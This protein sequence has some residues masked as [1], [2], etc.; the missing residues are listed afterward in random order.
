MPNE[1]ANEIIRNAM[2]DPGVYRE[3]AR[4]EADVWSNHFGDPRQEKVRELEVQATRI[5]TQNRHQLRL[6]AILRTHGIVP[7]RGLSLGCGSGRAERHLIQAGVCSS[8]HGIDIA[9]DAI[10]KARGY[11]ADEKVECTYE[12]QDLNTLSLPREEYD[13]VV[14]QTSL[15]H[16]LRLEHVLDAVRSSLKPMG[17]FW[18]HDY[19]GESQFQFSDDRLRIMNDLL[20]L[21]PE[22]L[23]LKS[24][25]GKAGRQDRSPR[26]R[27][28][29]LAFRKHPLGRDPCAAPGAFRRRRET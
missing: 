13:L 29:R 9:D 24:F 26:A 12:V 16:V 5:L 10:E 4:K 22:R 1:K 20:Q 28:A 7:E 18:V 23:R 21:L 19:I 25:Y 14:A 27:N 15:H 6:P 17:V 8:F 11:A 2:H 3:M